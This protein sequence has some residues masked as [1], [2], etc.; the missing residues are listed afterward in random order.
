MQS[1]CRNV[2]TVVVITVGAAIVVV[3][4]ELLVEVDVQTG[5]GNREEQKLSAARTDESGRKILYAPEVQALLA[6]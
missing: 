3:E 1:Q 6:A 4:I 2:P 5:K